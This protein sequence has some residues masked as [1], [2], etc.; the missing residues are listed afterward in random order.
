MGESASEVVSL[1]RAI[2]A[3]QVSRQVDK[4]M[5][6]KIRFAFWFFIEKHLLIVSNHSNKSGG[7]KGTLHMKFLK[8]YFEWIFSAICFASSGER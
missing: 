6:A 2:D 4:Q 7:V 3:A 1:A 5:D 8:N